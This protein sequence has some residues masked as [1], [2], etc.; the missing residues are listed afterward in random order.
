MSPIRRNRRLSMLISE[1]ERAM[2]QQVADADGLT[3][4]DYIRQHI[5]RAHA[6]RFGAAKAKKRK[7]KR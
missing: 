1:D 4:S 2:L 7:R 6:E 3:P 5:R